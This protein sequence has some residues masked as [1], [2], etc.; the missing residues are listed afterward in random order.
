MIGNPSKKNYRNM[1]SSN[2]IA[3]C[4]LSKSDVTNVRAIFGPDLA[5][6]QGKTVR[7]TPALVVAVYVAVPHLLVEANKVV[8]LAADVFFVEGSAFLLMVLCRMKFVTAE[9]VPTQAGTSLSKHL[10]W[11]LGVHGKAGFKVRTVL[12]DGDFKIIKPLMP[13]VECN[14]TAAKEH[15]SKAEWTIRTLKEQM[16]GLLA[17][18]PFSNIPSK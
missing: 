15:V 17:T 16:P 13:T 2:M 1:V 3:N 10:T 8:T 5:S 6:V 18:L 7:H 14:T 9:H 12:M 11:V 4:P